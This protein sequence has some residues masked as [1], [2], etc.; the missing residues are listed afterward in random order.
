MRTTPAD[1]HEKRVI[2]D[3]IGCDDRAASGKPGKIFHILAFNLI[4]H[5]G[6]RFKCIKGSIGMV[7]SLVKCWDINTGDF[8]GKRM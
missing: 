3:G 7:C 4:R 8:M 1:F 2:K 5:V 6:Y